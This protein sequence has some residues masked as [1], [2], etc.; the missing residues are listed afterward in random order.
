MMDG[1]SLLLFV[2]LLGHP[3]ECHS[4]LVP[5]SFDDVLACT[6]EGQRRAAEWIEDHPGYRLDAFRCG[7]REHAL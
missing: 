2:C 4:V 3:Q 6:V 5:E 1:A 7:P